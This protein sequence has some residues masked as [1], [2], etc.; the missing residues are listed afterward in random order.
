MLKFTIALSVVVAAAFVVVVAGYGN[1]WVN[2]SEPTATPAS[3]GE[4]QNHDAFDHGDHQGHEGHGQHA[5]TTEIAADLETQAQAPMG[6]RMAV[7][8]QTVCP[9]SGQSLATMARARKAGGGSSCCQGSGSDPCA[10][11]HGAGQR[12]NPTD[13][14]SGTHRDDH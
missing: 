3:V 5:P 6:D 1:S 10:A 8:G 13:G 2:S 9:M 12:R 7:S 11:G 14:D 4:H